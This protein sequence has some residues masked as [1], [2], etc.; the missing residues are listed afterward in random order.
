MMVIPAKQKLVYL[1]ADLL[2]HYVIIIKDIA[3]TTVCHKTIR[4]LMFLSAQDGKGVPITRQAL[5][6]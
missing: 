3:V 2:I 6:M 4:Y 1:F 5:G